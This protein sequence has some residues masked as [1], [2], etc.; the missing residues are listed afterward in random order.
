MKEGKNELIFVLTI[1]REHGA[2]CVQYNFRFSEIS[3][4][5]FNENVFS[6]KSDF[7]VIS[8]DDRGKR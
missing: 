8:I 4:S 1:T 3:G 7:R 5:H 2:H 6:L